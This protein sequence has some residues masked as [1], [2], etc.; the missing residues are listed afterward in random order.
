VFYQPTTNAKETASDAVHAA[1]CLINAYSWLK[2]EVRSI[3][4]KYTLS[5]P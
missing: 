2:M 3:I 1:N 5:G 4:V